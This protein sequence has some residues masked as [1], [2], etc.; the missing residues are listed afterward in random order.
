MSNLKVSLNKFIQLPDWKKVELKVSDDFYSSYPMMEMEVEDSRIEKALII[1]AHYQNKSIEDF[2]IDRKHSLDNYWPHWV[3]SFITPRLLDVVPIDVLLDK[4][5]N[6]SAC[7]YF[8][9]KR[10]TQVRNSTP[11]I[12]LRGKC[13]FH[14]FGAEH[15]TEEIWFFH[16]RKPTEDELK[17]VEQDLFK[18][19]NDVCAYFELRHT[20]KKEFRLMIEKYCVDGGYS[21]KDYFQDTENISFWHYFY[22]TYTVNDR[23]YSTKEEIL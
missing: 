6:C 21:L 4:V 13:S 14:L 16:D 9:G 10:A 5:G 15:K 8:K 2:V 23:Q 12:P 22:N 18:K 11:V 1:C 19:P 7:K 3:G 20:K 17:E